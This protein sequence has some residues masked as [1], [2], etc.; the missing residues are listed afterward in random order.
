M[1][2][3]P[4]PAPASLSFLAGG[5]EMGA[6]MR[7]MDWSR[8]VLG[9]VETWPQS[10]RSTLS[11]LLPSKA[12]IILFWGPEFIVF[13]ND[14]Y[15]PV[16]GAKHPHALGLPGRTAW[17]EIWDSV[18]HELLAGVVRTGEAFWAKDLLFELARYGFPEETYFDVSYDPVRVESGVVGGVFCIVTET[19]ERVIGERRMSLLKDL[20]ARNATARTARDACVL[21]TETLAARPED[22]TFALAY[23]GDELQCCTPDAEAKLKSADPEL[24]K[25]LSVS[26]GVGGHTGRLIVGLNP[27]RPFDDHYRAFVELVADQ[28]GMALANARAYEAERKR[29]EALAEIDRAKT[30][31]FSNVSHEFRTPLTL[32]LGPVQDAL[33]APERSLDAEALAT[34]NRNALR[35]L[36]LVNTLLDFARLEAGRADASFEPTDLTA[37]TTDLAGAFRSA[38]E[39]AGLRF[40]V[41]CTP[42]GEAAHVDRSMWEKIVFNLLS[43]ALKFTF[44]GGIRLALTREGD[45]ARLTVSDTGIGIAPDELPRVF[46]RF[47][48]VRGTR[49]RTH[50]GTGIGLSLVQE[51]VRLHGGT[52]AV[53][54]RAGSGTAFTVTLPLGARHGA[55]QPASPRSLSSTSV[56]AEAYV[57]EA[58]GW[59]AEGGDGALH[60]QPPGPQ[61]A[62][63]LL[64]DD[65]AD[66][67]HYVARLLGERWHVEAVPDGAAAL[68]AAR[69]QRP[70]VIVADVMMP[71]M[72]GFGLLAALRADPATQNIPVILLSARAGE[73]ATLKGIAAGADDYLVKPFTARDLLARVD[74]QLTRARA[75]EA[76]AESEQRFRAFVT[77][78]S[79]VVYRMNADWSEMQQLQGRDFIADMPDPSR[80]W[81]DRYIHPDDQPAV[82]A[83]IRTAIAT[84]STFEL[85]HRVYRIDGTLGWTFSRAV[86]I[87]DAGGEILE[88]LGTAR[89]VTD[90]RRDEEALARLTVYSEQQRRLYETILSST[91]DLVYVFGLDHR[92]IYANR[93]LLTMWGKTWDEAIGRNFLELGY[94][95]WHAEMHDREIEQVIATKAAIRGEVPFTGTHGRRM[96]DYIFVPVFGHDG[97][98]EAIAGATRD[99][100]ERKRFEDTLRESEQRLSEANRVKD[101]FL[102]TL[103]H[104]LRTP[105]NAVL[106]WAHMLRTGALRPD[107]QERAFQ[108]LERNAKAQAQLVDDLLDVSRIMSGK[109]AIK[110]E[111]FDL[112]TV[113]AAA[114]DAVRPAVV[115]KR[116]RLEVGVDPGGEIV[117]QGDPDRLQQV[118]WNILSN[119]VKFTPAGGSIDVDVQSGADHVEIIVRD[120]GDGIDPAF[121]P[122]VF[123]RFRQADSAPSRKHGGLGLGL[124]IVRHLAEA[125]GGT[126][127]AQSDG[128]GTGATFVVRLPVVGTGDRMRSAPP[129]SSDGKKTH[130]IDGV[131]IL[132]VDDEVDARELVRFVLENSGGQVMGV[133]SAGE[134]LHLL[135]HQPFDALVADIGMPQQDGHSLIR[136]IRSLPAGEGGAIPAIAVTAYA[137][138]RDRDDALAAG[139]ND[140]LGKPIDPERLIAAVAAAARP[141]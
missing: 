125:H 45:S 127:S 49:A 121:L 108:S 38:V 43:N 17:S 137:T 21:A 51:L 10:L 7:A 134:A 3:S 33:A 30:A 68:A 52:I 35:L 46:E 75:R 48:R 136:V 6:R 126:V 91:P 11:M 85:E 89:D 131:R 47:H 82:L 65:N 79:D 36:K 19:T 44:D 53:D 112:T 92:F 4:R 39:S 12:Q 62:R 80:T 54:S 1:A 93:A 8:T 120:S 132:V 133:A 37:F 138:L 67:R 13:Y 102:A 20:A 115:A 27:R 57:S 31:F 98:V 139:F 123:E 66:M 81:I 114:V 104:E 16:F 71:E 78:T 124:A 18:L 86:P 69:A 9:P 116:L 84:K 83:A 101:E 94:E 96:Y 87:L 59:V 42:L 72:D 109:L 32:L 110:S 135:R 56:N 100:T 29:A 122:Y 15:R 90:R 129:D 34:V 41:E 5:G 113:I 24:V 55:E 130:A 64:A 95:P 22:I 73:E 77:A 28:L 61:Q 106:G 60:L 99:I 40:D 103:S 76:V 50:E 58:L 118:V 119:A 63:I 14:A 111:I 25:E 117:I 74:A 105:L 97:E 140:H 128:P 70:D 26:P 107:V 23:L 141:A 88:W 2:E